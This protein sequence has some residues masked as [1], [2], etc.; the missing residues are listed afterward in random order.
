MGSFNKARRADVLRLIPRR[1]RN[2]IRLVDGDQE[3]SC[4]MDDMAS[5][6]RA[7]FVKKA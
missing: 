7:C 3:I 4:K 5:G 1:N 2:P 6:L